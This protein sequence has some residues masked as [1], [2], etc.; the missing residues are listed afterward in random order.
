[1]SLVTTVSRVFG[2]VRDQIQAALLG[3]TFIADAFAIGFILPNLLRRLFAE[4][5]MVASFIPVF[6]EL[7]KE[8]GIEESKK[9]FR[10]VFTLLGLI[11]IVVVGIGIIISPLL[12]KIL[13][14]SAHNNIEALNLASDLSRIMFPYLLFISLAA[15]MQGVLNIR[16]YYSIS[17]ASPILLNTVIISMALFFKFFCL[18]SLIIWLMYLLLLYYL[19]GLY[20]LPI[21]CLLYIN[22]VL[23]SSLIFILKNLML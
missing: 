21:K 3:T 7:E 19:E 17:A 13:Y 22:R 1:M 12:V 15:L 20:N 8:K 9:F 18:I 2:L 14:K 10:A 4:G 16:G 11:L 5:N 23:V 6:T